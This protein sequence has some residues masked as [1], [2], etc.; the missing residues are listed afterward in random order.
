MI[1]PSTPLGIQELTFRIKHQLESQFTHLQ[2]MGEI[3]NQK[4][5]SSGHLYFDLKEGQAKI[6]AVMFKK[7][8]DLLQR[9]PKEGDKIVATASINVYPP[10]G[11]YQLIVTTLEYQGVGELLLKFEELKNRLKAKGWFAEERKKNLPLLPKTIGV[12]TSPTGAVIRDIIHVLTRRHSGFHLILNPVR[13]QGE[14]AAQEIATAIAE[15]NHYQLAD[16]IIVGRGGGSLEDLWPFN[17]E[18]TAEAIFNSRI[19][20]IS[21]V[22]HETDFTL[23][24]FVADVRAPTPSAAAE[25]VTAEKSEKLTLLVKSKKQIEGALRQLIKRQR[26]RLITLQRHP[27]LLNPLA[28]LSGPLQKLDELQGQIEYASQRKISLFKER[29][30]FREKQLSSLNPKNVLKRGYSILFAENEKSVVLSSKQLYPK[31]K[32]TAL[33]S[34]GRATM[35]VMDND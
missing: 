16:V 33:F 22:G 31:Q 29:L 24:D 9:P 17:E 34:E 5:H 25:I 10:Q 32:I 12:I 19:P 20:I 23:A 15:M 1:Q 21:A 30:L 27:V 28:L 3:S 2:V 35:Q 11:K 26:E 8:Y 6:S 14:G 13:V 18:V 7:Q 4:L